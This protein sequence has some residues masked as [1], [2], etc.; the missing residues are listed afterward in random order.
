M[1]ALPL[2]PL[3]LPW[4]PVLMLIGYAVAAL[5]AWLERRDGRADAEPALYLLLL[6]A[7]L[8]ARIGFVAQHW[9]SYSSLLAMFDIRDLGFAPWPGAIVALMG[10][11]LWLWRRPALRRPLIL[12]AAS[13]LLIAGLLGGIVGISQPLRTPLPEVTL[14]TLD[15]AP[16]PLAA[17]RGTPL[18]LNLWATWCPPCAREL[19]LLVHAARH[20]HGVR[21][22]LIDQGQDAAT[23]R[24]YLRA[25]GLD[26]PLVL[27]DGDGALLRAY[28]SPG[29]PTTLF[30]ASDGRL[31]SAHVGEL[32]QATLAQALARLR[33]ASRPAS[34]ARDG[35]ALRAHASPSN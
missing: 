29:L 13:G 31:V 34:A 1:Q 32:S 2:G 26:P 14:R 33:A 21:I 27:L 3:V 4:G 8:A 9:R 17:L 12:S 7:L 15:G 23:V 5:V 18:V 6:L 11:A 25:R 30:I 24:A 10:G 22:V 28:H 19:P 20:E 16:Q 35:S